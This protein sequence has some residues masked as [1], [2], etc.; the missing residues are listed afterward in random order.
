MPERSV[1]DLTAQIAAGL[2]Y[3]A[4]PVA[5]ALTRIAGFF[6]TAAG[7][8][9]SNSDV[10]SDAAILTTKLKHL[11]TALNTFL[12]KE[13]SDTGVHTQVSVGITDLVI[14]SGATA[15]SQVLIT[16]TYITTHNTGGNKSVAG[17]D[18][19][20]D[21]ETISETILLDDSDDSLDATDGSAL[22]EVANTTYTILCLRDLT[23][24]GVYTTKFV[25]YDGASLDSTF[26]STDLAGYN[27]RMSMAYTHARIV[28]AVFNDLN[29]DLEQP[30]PIGGG[31][32]NDLWK[33][34]P[35]MM[36]AGIFSGTG[37]STEITGLGFTPDLV[38]VKNTIS[39]PGPSGYSAYWR[40][41]LAGAGG[42]VQAFGAVV[43]LQEVITS[44]GYDGFTVGT[45]DQGNEDSQLI[46]W[47]AFKM[48]T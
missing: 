10:A 8:G 45:A 35:M 2:K 17:L 47:I 11:N 9:I 42:W 48:H 23:T 7:L 21:A 44:L 28:G 27:T 33:P 39:L 24:G 40:Y 31:S 25:F 46:F 32:T 19:D 38:I 4:A 13:H 37:T 5:A 12:T 29:E 16:A 41:V 6:T 34:G 3:K 43:G 15:A 18:A 30:R 1:S 14:E 36:A 20:G 26:Y 22:V